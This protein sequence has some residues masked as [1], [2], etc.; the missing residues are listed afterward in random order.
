MDFV[1]WIFIFMTNIIGGFTDEL[2]DL[3][4][5]IGSEVAK[6]PGDMVGSALESMGMKGMKAGTTRAVQPQPGQPES[7]MAKMDKMTDVRQ[8]QAHARFVLAEMAGNIDLYGSAR[9]QKRE[10][11]IRER[12]EAEEQQKKDMEKEQKMY[13]QASA[14]N[15]P[16]SKAKRGDPYAAKRSQRKAEQKVTSD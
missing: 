10:P 13:A 2:G 8:K 15:Q 14:L 16:S 1:I 6:L 4:K 12:L 3:A 7:A 5:S 11:S 9:A